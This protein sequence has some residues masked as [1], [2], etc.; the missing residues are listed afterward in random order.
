[1][2]KI[3]K[4]IAVLW[5]DHTGYHRAPMIKDFDKALMPTLTVGIL[6]KETPK[7]IVVVSEI[8]RY[9]DQADEASYVIILKDAII[10]RK[11]YGDIAL[12][13]IS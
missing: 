4:I 8:E 7:Y 9:Q 3:Y 10:S 6:Y 12:E 13:K 5:G 11:E 1:M 2:G